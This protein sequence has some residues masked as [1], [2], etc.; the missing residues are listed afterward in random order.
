MQLTHDQILLKDSLVGDLEAYGEL[1]QCYQ[2]DIF[3]VCYRLTGNVQE[4]ED[5]TQETF[6]RANK[7]LEK[8]DLDKPFGPW[9][10]KIATNICL[11]EIKKNRRITVP[12]DDK[13]IFISNNPEKEISKKE[14]MELIHRAILSLPPKQRVVIELRHYQDLSYK[15]IAQALDIPISDVKS[16]LFRGRKT[17]AKKLKEYER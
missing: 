3:N 13:D 8:F 10:R 16:H 15:E 2:K 6:L 4:A 14:D 9:I 5:L 11:N 17:L 12:L 7:Y 1:V